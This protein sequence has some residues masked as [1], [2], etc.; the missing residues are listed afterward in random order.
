MSGRGLIFLSPEDVRRGSKSDNRK[1]ANRQVQLR[2][3][4]RQ[5]RPR[6][7]PLPYT[8]KFRLGQDLDEEHKHGSADACRRLEFVLPSNAWQPIHP[9]IHGGLA[10]GN[11]ADQNAMWYYVRIVLDDFSKEITNDFWQVFVLQRSHH[12]SLIQQALVALSYA[13]R[14][15]HAACPQKHLTS[16]TNMYAKVVSQLRSYIGCHH[17]THGTVITCAVILAKIQELL[18]DPSGTSLH[19]GNGIAVLNSWTPELRESSSEYAMLRMRLVRHDVGSRALGGSD[20]LQLR[21]K[22]HHATSPTLCFNNVEQVD[23]HLV[24]YVG[25]PLLRYP[26]RGDSQSGQIEAP[27]LAELLYIGDEL[28]KWAR[29]A[30]DFKATDPKPF[31]NELGS[32][33]VE[34]HYLTCKC[35]LADTMQQSFPS[36]TMSWDY[37]QDDFLEL[38]SQA[39]RAMALQQQVRREQGFPRKI[40][41][42]G[43]GISEALLLFASKTSSEEASAR[44][45]QLANGYAVA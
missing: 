25:H 40:V 26:L 3:T 17:A 18:G 31:K 30:D 23:D 22:A 44:A 10:G 19:M 6:T 9:Q 32:L 43:R 20:T 15:C 4:R 42:R 7:D 24:Q 45:V 36:P 33:L 13:H 1:R 29:A 2:T 11:P 39:V 34:S 5:A 27:P 8:I 35:L 28:V 41:D 12:E 16:P 21:P 14:W 37:H 38:G